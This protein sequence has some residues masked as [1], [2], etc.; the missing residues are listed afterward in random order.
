MKISILQLA[1]LCVGILN[2]HCLTSEYPENFVVTNSSGDFFN[3][4][5]IIIGNTTN[6]V[7]GNL[8]CLESE[9]FSLKEILFTK[10]S[11]KTHEKLMNKYLKESIKPND[12]ITFKL[13]KN[14]V[15]FLI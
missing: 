11:P 13:D 1:I 9:F 6:C 4:T 10:R 14:N 12:Q 8:S 7:L 2:I 15:A 3:M 5:E